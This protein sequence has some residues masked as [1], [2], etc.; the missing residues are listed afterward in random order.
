MAQRTYL[1]GLWLAMWALNRYITR[2]S[3]KLEDNMTSQ[4][5]ACLQAVLAAISECLPLIQPAP[6]V[7]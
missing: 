3:V 7:E 1:Y 5:W 4:Q 2:W 6:P